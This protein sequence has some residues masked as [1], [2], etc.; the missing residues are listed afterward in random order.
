MENHKKLSKALFL[1]RDGVINYDF[2]YVSKKNDFVFVDGIFNLVNF[3][4]SLN[5]LVIVA[6]NQAGIARNYYTE[7]EFH[8]L[9]NWMCDQFILNG[10][11]IHKI[12]YSPYHPTSGIGEYLRDDFSRKPNPGMLLQACEDYFIDPKKS[13]F[14][15]DKATDI[16]AGN[17]AGIGTNLLFAAERPD[18]LNGLSYELIVYLSDA[19][20]YLKRGVR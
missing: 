8:E 7:S 4:S 1:D 13:V 18:E 17:A 19:I 14:I 5:Y 11:K 15:G 9:S 16:Q 2:G 6:T 3:A 10:S 20:P 12:Y